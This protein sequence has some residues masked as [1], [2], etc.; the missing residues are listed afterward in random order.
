M[1]N[2]LLQKKFEKEVEE[3]SKKM[4]VYAG[5]ALAGVGAFWVYKT[6]KKSKMNNEEQDH[7]YLT[8]KS[9]DEDKYK[10]LFDQAIEEEEK[11]DIE[12]KE[13]EKKVEEF[14]SRRIS[15]ENCP[16]VSQ[17]EMQDF[18]DKVKDGK[19][20][21]EVNKEDYKEEDYENYEYYDDNLIEKK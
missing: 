15:Y 11:Q 17:E 8:N 6:M 4:M 16:Q 1:I 3:N 7:K 10:E 2:Y 9:Y 20:D 13:L 12:Q 19:N 18:L 5:I 14:N 21:V